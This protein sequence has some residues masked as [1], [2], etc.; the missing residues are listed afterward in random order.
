MGSSRSTYAQHGED[1]EALAFFNL[2]YGSG[3]QGRFLD[4]GAHDG[5]ANS[6]VRLFAER[7][8][9]GVCVEPDARSFTS[10]E[11]LYRDNLDVTCVQALVTERG[12]LE[13]WWLTDDGSVST[14]DT[15]HRELWTR[16]AGVTY[17]EAWAAAITP[18]QL[19][20]VF[21]PPYDLVSI[22]TEGTSDV[23]ALRFFGAAAFRPR[24]VIVEQGYVQPAIC[25]RMKA[26]GYRLTTSL[27]ATNQV[28][29][30]P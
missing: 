29:V 13:R 18:E 24:Y 8:W 15:R 3:Y 22:D 30:V 12:G 6:N 27:A 10:L 26:L 2:A 7:G 25:A 9:S 17:R 5:K 11:V 16:Q 14:V 4:A 1:V 20:G 19:L 23:L 28:W 21:P